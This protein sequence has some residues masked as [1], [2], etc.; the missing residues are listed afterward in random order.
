MK[1][2]AP[3]FFAA[4]ADVLG[5]PPDALSLETTFA[6]IP[7]WDSM[8]QLR[9][10]MDA[11]ARWGVD[12]PFADVPDVTSLWELFRRV[13]AL[14]PKKAVVLDLDGTLWDGVV[15]EDGV[16]AL[17]PKTAF[18]AEL[19]ALKERGVL[20]AACSKNNADDAQAAFDAGLLAPLAADDF[21]AA[22]IGWGAK[23]ES[24]RALSRELNLGLDAF[25]FVD[26]SPA[27]RLAM[28][29][30][31]PEVTVA[32]FPP[33]LAAFF[34]KGGPV[35]EED[36]RKTEEYREEAERR[37][38]LASDAADAT[39]AADGD[40]IWAALG[41]WLDVHPLRPEEVSR[42][43]QLSQKANQF[44]VCANRYA[45]DAVAALGRGEGGA[46]VFAVR[47]GDRFGDMG[48][49]AFVV[50]K[51]GEVVDFTMSCRAAGRGLEA[52][53]WAEV[54]R[55]LRARGVRELRAT[56][57]R[58]GKNEPVRDLFDRLGFACESA[59]P[60]LRRYVKEI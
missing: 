15:G 45:T 2:D 22:K 17:R 21:V 3:E 44:T 13:N 23:A 47:A 50:V 7:E 29:A 30:A 26:D 53:A 49:V 9:L 27:E 1:A 33:T 5:V 38:F 31:L 34:P 19:K 12:V 10:V 4:V 25:V 54:V 52:R 43:A 42:V 35:T 8:A 14:S 37:K 58:T 46:A 39:G 32:S 6:S 20:L 55:A 36:R 16:A 18:L 28:A 11:A 40:G 41:A 57:R 24:V 59:T 56:W 60:D 51:G 48:L